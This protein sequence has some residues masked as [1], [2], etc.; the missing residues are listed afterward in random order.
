MCKKPLQKLTYLADYAQ[1]ASRSEFPRHVG[2]TV[3]HTV[4]QYV[5]RKS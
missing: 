3:S 5:D 4:T 1:A 2:V